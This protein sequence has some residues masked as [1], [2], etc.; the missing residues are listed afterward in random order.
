MNI[1]VDVARDYSRITPDCETVVV[2]SGNM[3]NFS[4]DDWRGV[5]TCAVRS[6]VL[7]AGSSLRGRRT[8]RDDSV[9]G[10]APRK[11]EGGQIQAVL[12]IVAP[13]SGTGS[14][15]ICMYVTA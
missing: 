9:W 3:L 14:R 4:H 8:E 11:A 10:V 7:S 15:Y 1:A 2:I 13:L 5:V 6:L 12:H